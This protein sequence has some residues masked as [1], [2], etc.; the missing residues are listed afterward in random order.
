MTK[1]EIDAVLDRVRTWSPERQADAAQLL[2][3]ME[4]Q[5]G[6]VYKLSPEELADIEESLREADRGEFATDEEV[7]A[8][9]NRARQ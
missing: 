4:G 3:A 5:N 7:A 6:T 8:M 2:L 9:F 1:T